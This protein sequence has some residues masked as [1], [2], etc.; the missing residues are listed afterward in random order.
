MKY[1]LQWL[2][3]QEPREFVMFWGVESGEAAVL[4]QWHGCP[5]KANGL[6]Y[7][8]A[9]HYMMSQ[10]ALAC[11]DTSTHMQ[12]LTQPS[13]MVAKA[14]GRQIKSYDDKLWSE[15]RYDKVVEGNYHKFSAHE[16]LKRYLLSTGDKVLVEASPFDTIWGIGLK[17]SEKA[18]WD[19]RKWKGQNLLG[20]ALMEV[21]DMLREEA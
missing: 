8:T 5:F 19:P 4:S 11:D 17:E 20:F 9:E 2:L 14:L 3:E 21:R 16:D 1:N 10:K 15:I 12:I 13:P 18:A 6:I 7:Q